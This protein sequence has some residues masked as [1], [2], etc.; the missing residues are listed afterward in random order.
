MSWF[1]SRS[2]PAGRGLGA[3]MQNQA[4]YS[5]QTTD[6]E[7][8][9]PTIAMPIQRSREEYKITPADKGSEPMSTRK[10]KIFTC[11]EVI[12]PMPPNEGC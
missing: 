5:A 2:L 9:T 6:M 1:D 12:K 8:G 3:R 11:R 4:A 10:A 7:N